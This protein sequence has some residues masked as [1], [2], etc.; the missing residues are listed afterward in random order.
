VAASCTLIMLAAL[1]VPLR[2]PRFLLYL[3]KISYGLY[4]YHALGNV[5]SGYILRV[6]SNFLQLALRPVAA[7]AITIL[8]GAASY[9][10]LE[11]PFLKLKQR[12]AHIQSRPV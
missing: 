11:T 1:G 6:H 2:M 8:L 10:F 12:F 4:V 7:L 5:L 3:G 9:A